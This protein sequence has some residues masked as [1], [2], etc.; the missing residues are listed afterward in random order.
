MTQGNRIWKIRLVDVG[1]VTADEAMA[2]GFSGPMLRG[3]GIKWDI[4]KVR[5]DKTPTR[6]V[7]ATPP[8]PQPQP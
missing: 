2:W 1:N 8:T 7:D 4:R 6:A 3:S 5:Q